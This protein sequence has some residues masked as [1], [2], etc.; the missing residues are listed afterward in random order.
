MKLAIGCLIVA[1][2]TACASQPMQPAR[3]QLPRPPPP[4]ETMISTCDLSVRADLQVLDG[5]FPLSLH[6][7]HRPGIS[8]LSTEREP[9][10]DEQAA[11]A[12]YDQLHQSC[13]QAQANWCFQETYG[14]GEPEI[15]AAQQKMFASEQNHLV[16]LYQGRETF[17]QFTRAVNT[18]HVTFMSDMTRMAQSA[19]DKTQQQIRSS[20][21]VQTNCQSYTDGSVRCTTE[22]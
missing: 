5:K 22:Q 11:L 10:T 18:L 6:Q 15:C 12:L 19:Y 13:V 14:A 16:A 20:A 21:P 17:A 1:S 3:A 9:T 4:L 8:L 7:I 2:L